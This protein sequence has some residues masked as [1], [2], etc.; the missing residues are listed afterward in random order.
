MSWMDEQR[1]K[2]REKY[3][4]EYSERHRYHTE[5]NSRDCDHN[6]Q[7]SGTLGVVGGI[8]RKCGYR[9]V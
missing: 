5:M 7:C 6:M 3:E 1:E 2:V 4:E 9:T 8:C